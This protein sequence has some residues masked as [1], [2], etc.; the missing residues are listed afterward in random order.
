MKIVFIGTPQF[1]AIILE[2]LVKNGHKPV[3]VIT[4]TD[5]PTGRKQI[6]TPPPVKVLAQKYNISVLQPSKILDT[7]YR[8]PN[9]KPRWNH[10]LS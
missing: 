3:L 1:G 6:I 10:G 7:K 9:T 5:K 4:E 8:T 2:G